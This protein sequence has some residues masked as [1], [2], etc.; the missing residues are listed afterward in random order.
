MCTEAQAG[1]IQVDSVTYRRL[2]KRFSFDEAHQIQVKGKGP[3]QVFN[4]LRRTKSP[5]GDNVVPIG[6]G[7][8]RA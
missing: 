5:E 2:H 8:H 3:M 1:Y 4:L 6:E 7:L